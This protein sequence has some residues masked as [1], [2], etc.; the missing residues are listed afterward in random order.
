MRHNKF[1]VSM[2]IMI[3]LLMLSSEIPAETS[4]VEVRERIS[5]QQLLE[6]IDDTSP[7]LQELNIQLE[8]ARLERTRAR[9][10]LRP[11]AFYSRENMETGS[12]SEVEQTFGLSQ[13]ISFLWQRRTQVRAATA[14]LKATQLEL[15]DRRAEIGNEIVIGL[16]RLH[17]IVQEMALIDM[18][19]TQI[20][21]VMKSVKQ[22]TNLGEISRFE[23]DRFRMEMTKLYSM[24][25]EIA[26]NQGQVLE[27]LIVL[28]G[29]SEQQLRQIN[30][31][32]AFSVKQLDS[33]SLVNVALAS[34][35]W[36]A[37]L[38]EQE[39]AAQE[40]ARLATLLALPSLELEI[41]SKHVKG[42]GSGFGFNV[43]FSFDMLAERNAVREL[44]TASSRSAASA[45]I[46]YEKQLD[47]KIRRI[48]EQLN[49]LQS[50]NRSR[51]D[52]LYLQN[53]SD[54]RR[55]YIEGELNATE[56]IDVMRAYIDSFR[57]KNSLTLKELELIL[58]LQ[59]LL[60]IGDNL[61]E[62]SQNVD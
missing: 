8:A 17:Q 34:N 45:R 6:E 52:D 26:D 51:K 25:Q 23:A 19:S 3:A 48:L 39:R 9:V 1:N 38:R 11:T 4:E 36:I 28:T 14:D 5:T 24:R 57:S 27:V 7:V 13:D 22:R 55:L 31:I 49:L 56:L 16:Q 58:E 15:L 30:V 33:D 20:D 50:V 21:F 40:G 35:R 60:G 32:P 61:D 41:G 43:G 46:A 53:I 44:S 10:I 2:M 12:A 37:S 47:A 59:R 42:G 62:Q 18:V 29:V 54:A